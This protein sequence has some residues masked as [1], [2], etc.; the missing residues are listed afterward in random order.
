MHEQKMH[1]EASSEPAAE[2]GIED[3]DATPGTPES[4]RPQL[5]STTSTESASLDTE[6]T[7]MMYSFEEMERARAPRRPA[8]CAAHCMYSGG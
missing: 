5:S 4:G 1:P 2:E 7:S 8:A 6:A 3:E